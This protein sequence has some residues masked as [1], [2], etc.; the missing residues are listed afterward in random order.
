ISHRL[1]LSPKLLMRQHAH[2]HFHHLKH[3]L[4][5]RYHLHR[6]SRNGSVFN[7][8]Q[9][10]HLRHQTLRNQVVFEFPAPAMLTNAKPLLHPFHLRLRKR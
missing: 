7:Q 4:E 2:L 1:L 8:C 6:L 3:R 10:L 9:V 5:N